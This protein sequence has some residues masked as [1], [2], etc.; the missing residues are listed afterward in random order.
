MGLCPARCC[1]PGPR[2]VSELNEYEVS[3]WS[4]SGHGSGACGVETKR[5]PLFLGTLQPLNGSLLGPEGFPG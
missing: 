1:G 2:T 4:L 3:M 5:R